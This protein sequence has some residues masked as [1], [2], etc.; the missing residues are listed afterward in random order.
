MRL[1]HLST[2]FLVLALLAFGLVFTA[3][4]STA[5]EG[6]DEIYLKEGTVVEYLEGEKITIKVQGENE[7][8]EMN[9]GFTLTEDT[10]TYGEIAVGV[11]VEVEYKE[12]GVALFVGTVGEES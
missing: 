7:G 3:S 1:F 8:E 5:E 11:K 10:E 12:E 2:L 9:I 4:G 6:S